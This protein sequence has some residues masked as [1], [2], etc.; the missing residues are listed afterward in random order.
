MKIKKIKLLKAL[1]MT[2]AFG[3]VATV[4]VIVSSCSST[5]SG[6]GENNNTGGGSGDTGGGSGSGDTGGTT[7]N[8]KTTPKLKSS[9][10]LV[11]ALTDIYDPSKVKNTNT[12]LQ[13]EIKSNLDSAFEN[14][15]D[16]ENKNFNVTVKGDF[17]NTTWEGEKF[18]NGNWDKVTITDT[19]KLFYDSESP[20]ID[21][22]SLDDLKTKLSDEKTLKEALAKAGVTDTA[23]SSYTIKNELGL[24]DN[25]LLH[26][27]VEGKANGSS[28]L[29]QYDL[30]IPA[31]DINLDL[32][33][34]SISVSGDDVN[35]IEES[36][37]LN[38]NIGVNSKTTYTAP[39]ATQQLTEVATPDSV[40]EK[41]S[42]KATNVINNVARTSVTLT[43]ENRATST[44]MVELDVDKVAEALGIFNTKFNSVS[45]TRVGEWNPYEEVQDAQ[46]FSTYKVDVMATPNTGYY[47][48]DGTREAKTFSFNVNINQQTATFNNSNAVNI[49][50]QAITWNNSNVANPTQAS[51]LNALKEK[52]T[53]H[54]DGSQ[55]DE[56]I[57]KM[58]NDISGAMIVLDGL[59][60]AHVKLLKDAGNEYI[61]TAT[62]GK[63]QVRLT[64][65]PHKGYSAKTGTDFS[66]FKLWVTV[67]VS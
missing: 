41:L 62:G 4:P 10:N 16:L 35:P 56:S 60:D 30:Q 38:F 17:P 42:F 12:L 52:L 27:N 63:W 29:T 1:A 13:E 37:G 9:I 26:V 65:V 64:A 11:G 48:D 66:T 25:S 67:T 53:K 61:K 40:M 49:S 34:L 47:F 39:T 8:Q 32:S 15:K 5:N 36:V 21:I 45:L 24:T 28:T 50:Q 51:S 19:N 44:A 57:Q 22:S 23:N 33:K 20:Q 3:T 54:A 43:Q 2:G 7:Q 14:A 31:S 59:T 58:L 46:N 55:K 18:S 6:S